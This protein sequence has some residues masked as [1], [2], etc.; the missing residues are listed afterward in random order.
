MPSDPV[1]IFYGLMDFT[2]LQHDSTGM[3]RRLNPFV[4]SPL[5]VVVRAL[6]EVGLERESV[7]VDLGSGDG[8]VPISAN[9]VFGARAVGVEVNPRLVSYS[10]RIRDSLGLK[11]VEFVCVDA[12]SVDLRG[13]DVVFAYLT[14]EALEV[15]KPV[16][17]TAGEGATVVTHDYPIRGWRPGEVLSF[18][19]S[20]TQRRHMFYVYRLRDVLAG[21]RTPPMPASRPGIRLSEVVARVS[22]HI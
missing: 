18:H 22:E 15:L 13:V 2:F 12:R 8:R 20:E 19:S 11:G 4:P 1:R 21:L 16:L 14:S 9:R 5:D 10:R 6:G 7:L 3:E 17:L